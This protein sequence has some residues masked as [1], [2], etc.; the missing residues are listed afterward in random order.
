M[1]LDRFLA[2]SRPEH[3]RSV[4]QK[5]I[6]LGRVLVDGATEKN[7]SRS[8]D[9]R[10]L[11]KFEAPPASDFSDHSLPVLFENEDV[12]VLNKPA[13]ILT[14]AKGALDEEFTVAEFVRPKWSGASSNRSGIVHRLDRATSGVI[15]T[16]KN[17]RAAR[18]LQ[19]QFSERKA[20]KTYIAVLAHAPKNPAAKIDAP[21]GRN[22]KHPA[23]FR[24]DANGKSAVT[25][26]RVLAVNEA[27]Q[28]VAELKPETGRTHQLRVHMAFAG[29]SIVGDVIYGEAG[30][31][32]L[33][34]AYKLEISV[35]DGDKNRRMT[36]TA[37]LP[38]Y[39]L[40][41]FDDVKID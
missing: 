13:G 11:V 15:I 35:P 33:L 18:Y 3:S 32:M 4:W 23:E 38:E 7:I 41:G 2:D 9:E 21:I 24:V 29:A 19:K 31:Q 37:P 27:G 5:F 8:V 10:N 36:F 14:H 25:N 16:A 39:L 40:K 6:K 17:E 20:K 26:Y 28:V 30:E 12:L 1:R 34:H 22:P